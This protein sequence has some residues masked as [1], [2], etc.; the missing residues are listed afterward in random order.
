M[1]AIHWI[2]NCRIKAK[3]AHP[4]HQSGNEQPDQVSDANIINALN[5]DC[6]RVIFWHLNLVDLTN[7][8]EV[9]V[10]FNEHAKIAFK[11]KFTEL[12][13]TRADFSRRI[14][15]AVL[16]NFGKL[17][18]SLKVESMALGPDHEALTL[19]HLHTSTA[20]TEL[21]LVDFKCCMNINLPNAVYA[22]MSQVKQL[23]LE[24]CRFHNKLEALLAA[25]NQLSALR[26]VGS[27]WNEN[28]INRRFEQLKEAQFANN[29]ML[30]DFELNEF[31]ELN[32]TLENL[33]IT[34]NYEL[35]SSNTIQSISKNLPHLVKLDFE[36]PSLD[37]DDS[38][39]LK[40][41][42]TLGQLNSLKSLTFHLNYCDSALPLMRA[43][44]NGNV[45][46]EHLK[47]LGGSIHNDSV[48][49]M[50]QLKK[51]NI[52]ELNDVDGL[53]NEMLVE[54]AMEWPEIESFRFV[55]DIFH[56]IT[57]AGLKKCVKHAK[58]LANL[59]LDGE[60]D[61][62]TIEVIDYEELLEMVKNRPEQVQ[63]TIKIIDAGG[64]VNV[65]V[66]ILNENREW[67]AIEENSDDDPDDFDDS[68]D[69]DESEES[70]G[71]NDSNQSD[72]VMNLEDSVLFHL[73]EAI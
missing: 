21:H 32:P 27:R 66:S 70:F 35:L 7:A 40:N 56:N 18:R 46:I 39:F 38:N 13:I 50:S 45:P 10:R 68:G 22:L 48:K 16:R 60:L 3:P 28:A 67:L 31:I 5:D 20:L 8:A 73:F 15:K 57:I 72:H 4:L 62:C 55:T 64:V 54:L 37:E 65:P 9:C 53:T 23:T 34:E 61:S 47:L 6:L 29:F 41:A 71:S 59:T 36:Q 58:K 1:Q 49:F 19:I 42:D 52:F 43:L 44:A 24:Y 69:S 25:C 63:L 33:T 2:S 14:A 11:A 26:I 30:T 12:E 17:I 51:M